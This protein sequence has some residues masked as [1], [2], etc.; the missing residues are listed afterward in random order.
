MYPPHLSRL[1]LYAP[2][3]NP[4]TIQISKCRV[5]AIFSYSHTVFLHSRQLVSV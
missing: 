1:S 2:L 4:T 5:M 3:L